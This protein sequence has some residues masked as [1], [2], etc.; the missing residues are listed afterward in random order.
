MRKFESTADGG[1]IGVAE[2]YFVTKST[3][4][5]SN[6]VVTTT[7]RYFY[8]DVIVFKLDKSGEISWKKKIQKNQMTINEPGFM[9]SIVIKQTKDKLYIIFNDNMKNYD[10]VTKKFLDLE[11]PFPM[12]F[13][14]KNNA[15][16]IVGISLE[17]GEILREAVKGKKELGSLLVPKL[18]FP[19]P[20][21]SSILLYTV[22]GKKEMV[23]RI[24]FN[25]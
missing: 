12:T 16:A 6:G 5:N 3:S 17:D 11:M 23:G 13:S 1:Y 25:D 9:S 4:T 15:I 8:N 20:E 7:Y 2:E 22:M 10:P 14:E 24:N 18:C 19:D 21:N